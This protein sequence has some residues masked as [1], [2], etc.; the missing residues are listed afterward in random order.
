MQWWLLLAVFL[1]LGGLLLYVQLRMLHDT[2][3]QE[4]AR[5][6]TQVRMA[7]KVLTHQI[8]SVDAG[9]RTLREGLER[10]RTPDGFVPFAMEHL[11]RVEKMIPAA[12]TFVVLDERGRCQLSNRTELVGGDFSHRNYF[13]EGVALSTDESLYVSPP[14][15]TVL[16]AWAI[17]VSR[18]VRQADGSLRGVVAATLAPEFFQDLMGRLGYAADMRVSL[19]H[20]Q[21]SLYVTA[22]PDEAAGQINFLQPKAFIRQHLDSGREESTFQGASV[23]SPITPRLTVMRTVDLSELGT[24]NGFVATASR[25]LQALRAEWQHENLVLGL[26]FGLMASS[27]GA[28]LFLYQRWVRNLQRQRH[29]DREALA[30]SHARYEQLTHALPCVLFDFEVNDQGHTHRH[31]V[32]PYAERLLGL[33]AERLMAEPHRLLDLIHPEDRAAFEQ[34]HRH[35]FESLQPYDCTVRVIRT[36]GQTIWVQMT[37]RP[38]RMADTPSQVLWSG[39]MVD[40]TERTRMEAELRELA[41]HDPLTGA[42]NRRSFMALVAL[43]LERVHRTGTGSAVLMLDFDHFKH[44]N[45]TWGHD[46]GDAV[47]KTLVT[48]LMQAL[49]RIDTLGRVGGE[50]FAVLLPATDA[51]AALEA[52]ERLRAQA[53]RQT[54]PWPDAQPDGTIR[55]TVSI[56]VACLQPTTPDIHAALKAADQALYAAKAAGRNRVQMEAPGEPAEAALRS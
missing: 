19:I 22:P 25:D 56:G 29:E 55:I 46:A 28:S 50:E 18:P 39:F 3:S 52:A 34:Q 44:V 7:D 10:W 40:V 35:A 24:R 23:L 32:S 37:G 1:T 47:L 21:G 11:K 33:P 12:R 2:E 41:Y 4:R 5:L 30:R 43:E 48:G 45:D 13:A 16:G 6:V 15:R 8:A 42:H 26:T 31:Y 14:Y 27:A 54:V 49:R 20:S 9:L 36:D 38:T 17:T 51:T 53:Q